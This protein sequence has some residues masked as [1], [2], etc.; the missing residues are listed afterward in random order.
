MS[1][2]KY[3]SCNLIIKYRSKIS[4]GIKI[5]IDNFYLRIT[6]QNPIFTLWL[7]NRV[8]FIHLLYLTCDFC[9]DSFGRD[10]TLGQGIVKNEIVQSLFA[11]AINSKYRVVD[12]CG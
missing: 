9:Y 4:V 12:D 5:V 11:N 10:T 1:L 3:E 2:A 8:Y 6:P 7:C